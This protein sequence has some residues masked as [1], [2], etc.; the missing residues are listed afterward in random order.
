MVSV[1]TDVGVL[2]EG[3]VRA[4]DITHGGAKEGT[5]TTRDSY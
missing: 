1:I 2:S 3:M 5:Q 4:L